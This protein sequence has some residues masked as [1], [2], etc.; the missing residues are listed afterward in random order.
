MSRRLLTLAMLA[1]VAVI[2]AGCGSGTARNN[3]A[4]SGGTSTGSALA[5]AVKF[6]ECM[7]TNGVSGFPDPNT[8]GSFT[9]DAVAN[10]S[11]V[12]ARSPAFARAL[13][14]CRNLEPAGFTGNKRTPEQQAAAL[15][16]A[17]CMRDDGVPS[18]PDP[19]PDG[20]IID[21]HGAHSI[22]GFHGALEKCSV[23]YAG[24]MGVKGR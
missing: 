24:A 20:P 19:K 11:S 2:A 16:F 1:P 21:V 17:Q 23:I 10:G 12:D 22:P 14:A 7:R 5:K 3:S 6:S 9:I 13:V 15:K 18:F 4:A 8:S